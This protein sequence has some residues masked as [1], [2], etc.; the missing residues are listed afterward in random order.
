M[1]LFAITPGG[2]IRRLGTFP[3]NDADVSVSTDGRRMVASNYSFK[4]DIYMIRNFGKML[5][6]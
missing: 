6:R 3:L 2:P 4:N 5:R 1:A